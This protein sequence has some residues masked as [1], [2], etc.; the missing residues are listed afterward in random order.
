MSHVGTET[1]LLNT[2]DAALKWIRKYCSKKTKNIT[3][4][5]KEK[6]KAV[7]EGEEAAFIIEKLACD[8][9]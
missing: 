7:F 5:E 9:I 4:E 3:K 6:Y 8:I 1:G 2:D